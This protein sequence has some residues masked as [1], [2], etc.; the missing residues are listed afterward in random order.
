VTESAPHPAAV[1]EDGVSFA[2]RRIAVGSANPGK[3]AAVRQ[4]VARYWSRA[5]VEGIDVPSGVPDQPRNDAEGARGAVLRAD[6]ARRA[7]DADLGIGLEGSSDEHPWGM[8]TVAWVAAVD[9]AG[10]VG[11]AS[12][13]R[14]PLPTP[15]AAGI[16]A[17][18][19]LGPLVDAL[20]GEANT[21]HRGGASAAFTAGHAGRIDSLA[22]GVVYACA[23]FLT[24]AY[25]GPAAMGQVDE[26][27]A[28]LAE[29]RPLRTA[30]T[31]VFLHRPDG[32]VLMLHRTRPPNAGRL[33]G[34]GGGI[35]AGE[36]VLQAAARE[37]R[38]EVGLDV[39]PRLGLALTLWEAGRMAQGEPPILLYVCRADIT[40]EAAAQVPAACPEG[41]LSWVDPQALAALDVVPNLRVLLP[42]LPAPEAGAGALVGTLWY[43]AG[44]QGGRYLVHMPA[45]PCSGPIPP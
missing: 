1:P 28:R 45:G 32:R 11:L 21:K 9:R 16:R 37:V 24:P 27:L 3:I 14:C 42:L 5:T 39:Q 33:N 30:Y 29:A 35:E 8:Y 44:W 25:F 17:G 38:E 20:L 4:A 34:V 13:G 12:T 22:G 18:G 31:L 7:R 26:V 2:P 6:A 19:E 15:V 36:D 10:R 23:P 40:A 41:A 43:D